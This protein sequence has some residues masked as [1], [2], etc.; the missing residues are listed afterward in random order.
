MRQQLQ[1]Y[2]NNNPEYS[3]YLRMHPKW[4]RKLARHPE[5]IKQFEEEAKHFYGKTL[6]QQVN[7]VQE[8][9]SSFGMMVEL[10]KAFGPN[11][12]E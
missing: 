11:K 4:Y 6:P 10:L 1:T 3:Y 9:I 12:G 2:I 5:T 7:K 8:K